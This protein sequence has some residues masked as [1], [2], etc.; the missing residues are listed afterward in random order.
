VPIPGAIIRQ[1]SRQG[2]Q[3]FIKLPFNLNFSLS[4]YGPSPHWSIL[5]NGDQQ[6]PVVCCSSSPSADAA[7]GPSNDASGPNEK[8]MM[9]QAA[10]ECNGANPSESRGKQSQ[11]QG[12]D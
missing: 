3:N 9:L 8:K 11:A 12:T 4:R 5:S 1:C 10:C 2:I 7:S 6:P